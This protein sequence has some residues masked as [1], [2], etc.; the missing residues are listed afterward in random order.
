M[1]EAQSPR[2]HVG[3]DIRIDRAQAGRVPSR[4]DQGEAI[5]YQSPARVPSV[6]PEEER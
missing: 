3:R 2:P 1:N 5:A 6:N 4:I